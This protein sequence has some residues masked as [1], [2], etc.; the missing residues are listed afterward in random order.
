MRL[1]LDTH[2]WLWLQFSPRRMSA[3]AID[4]LRDPGNDLLFSAV[5]SW[6]IAIKYALG[7]LPL[8]EPPD[9]YVPKRIRTSGVTPISIEHVHAL[10]VAGL[11]RHH[12]DPFDRLM[13]SQAQIERLTV[14]TADRKF[15]PYDVQ[16]MW[17]S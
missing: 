6:E 17:V 13:V 16:T 11:P 12:D 14:V 2:V 5:S 4:L 8:P 7:K 15:E 9:S 10:Q 3:A 1:L